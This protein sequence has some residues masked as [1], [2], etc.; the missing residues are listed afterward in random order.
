[1]LVYS[2]AKSRGVNEPLVGAA[3]V[4]SQEMMKEPKDSI[5]PKKSNLAR[6]VN[7]HRQAQRPPDP[8][9]VDFTV[10]KLLI[11]PKKD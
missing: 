7:R 11:T 9:T 1:M 3:A 5:L 8:T 10:S 4:V 2:Q 6:V